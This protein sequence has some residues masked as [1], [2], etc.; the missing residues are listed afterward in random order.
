MINYRS[1]AVTFVKLL[2]AGYGVTV[3]LLL[4]LTFFVYR[5][6]LGEGQV[7]IFVAAVYIGSCF[8]GGFLSGKVWKRKRLLLGLL[9][10]AVYFGVLF[11][12]SIFAGGLYQN[13]WN[14]L[15]VCLM[16]L[17]GGALGGMLS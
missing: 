14:T 3:L 15:K 4:V 7:G 11:L 2:A 5:L 9:Y 16:C 10:A 17:A 6:G 13:W 8:L 1:K 12:L